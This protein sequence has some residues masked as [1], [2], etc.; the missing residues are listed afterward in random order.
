M[1][2]TIVSATMATLAMEEVALQDAVMLHRNGWMINVL[3]AALLK[4][5]G[6]TMQEFVSQDVRNRSNGMFNQ[7]DA[8]TD[9]CLLISG[10]REHV[11]HVAR[12]QSLGI[13]G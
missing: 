2:N 12:N 4:I 3:I 6:T 5:T 7:G 11:F 10:R 9:A 1:E 13:T 8:L